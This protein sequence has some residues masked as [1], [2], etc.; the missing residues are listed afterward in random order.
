M[1]FY[2]EQVIF[3]LVLSSNS[4][5]LSFANTYIGVTNTKTF[6]VSASSGNT[7]ETVTLSDN[8]DQYSF[9]PSTFTLSS[10]SSQTVTITFSPTSWGVKTGTVQV[11][12]SG[13]SVLNV[14]LSAVCV[15]NPLIITS[16]VGNINFNNGYVNET[17]STTFTVTA[18]GTVQDIVLMSD[19]SD[20]FDF[21][22]SSFS[23]TGANQSQVVTVYFTPTAGGSKLGVL[24]LSASGGDVAHVSL[25]G[26]GIFR[27]LVLTSS[28]DN[29][30]FADAF[31]NSTSSQTFTVSAGGVGGTET[32]TV[33]DNSNQFD[34]SPTSFA[35]T[36]GG[37]S[38]TVTASFTP[39]SLGAKTATLTLSA[40]GG[41]IKNVSLNGTATDQFDTSTVFTLKGEGTNNATNNTF[42]DSSTSNLSI[43]RN[44]TPTQ[45]TFSPFS[46]PNTGWSTYFN[47]SSALSLADNNAWTFSGDFTVEAWIRLPSVAG[48]QTIVAH[49]PGSV[50]TNC[51]FALSVYN[52]KL[53]HSYGI[54]SSNIGVSGATTLTANKWTHVAV[55]RSG[56]TLRLFVDGVLDATATVS[57]AYNNSTGVL[58]IG[59]TNPTD[60]GYLTGDISNLRIVKGTAVYTSAFTPSTSPLTAIA[61]TV[62]LT[63][64]D[65]R[66]KDNSS[67]NFACSVQVGSP[68]CY[69]HTPFTI[70]GTQYG[71]AY[72]NGS[73]DYLSTPATSSLDFGTGDFTIEAWFYLAG[74]SSVN[75]S[76]LRT[77]TIFSKYISSG[78]TNGYSFQIVGN[79]TTTGTAIDFT[80]SING[81]NA[82][83]SYATTIPLKTW[84]HAAVSRSGSTIRL[85]L[86][87]QLVASSAAWGSTAVNGTGYTGKIGVL[88]YTGYNNGI[89]GYISGLHVV[90]GTALYTA[91]FTPSTSAPVA[92]AGTSLL[93]NFTNAG[94]IDSM[95]N[96]QISTVGNTK[97]ST[98]Q[99]KYGSSSISFDGTNSVAWVGETANP[100]L[101]LGTGDF[102]IEGWI[103]PAASITG[104]WAIYANYGTSTR[105][106]A[107]IL[108]VLSSNS[109]VGFYVYPNA[110]DSL[111]STTALQANTWYHIALSRVS[112][113]TRLFI[114]G[115]LEAS[116][117]TGLTLTPDPLHAPTLGGY[118]QI[119][120]GYESAGWFNGFIDDFRVT[121]GI[122][123]Y[124]ANFTPPTAF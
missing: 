19:D 89:N 122:G 87:G 60:S 38:Q 34:F 117:A 7:T 4:S 105:N 67:N 63:C 101:D 10:T 47:G 59:F 115:V 123:R 46:K 50:A 99:S 108:R 12:A 85:F 103:R 65:S 17:A 43:T 73:T 32:V 120:G 107:H 91:A 56:T 93:A 61:N 52:N 64:Q 86:N 16:S 25:T 83:I 26:S 42:I 80:Q 54:G 98:T 62:L 15:A 118:W 21:S 41:S 109:K 92:V 96:A 110:S 37:S 11:S 82:T 119:T 2:S 3:P 121:K 74:N 76:N 23:M 53:Y 81:G 84:N 68:V 124:T 106:G 45:G 1:F 31:P 116:T 27:P 36:G 14:G 9:S 72:F 66:F 6:I 58:N 29:I 112:G 75:S 13:G 57:G 111:V 40:S 5:S 95:N 102:T 51:S 18:G 44:G 100:R 97:I 55:S 113:T 104:N 79:S 22:P 48:I 70:T 49:W 39:S 88:G 90:K 8:T 30:T 78:T 94:V 20:Q 35:L 28:A 77:A 71:S 114:N 69:P 24:T 33:S